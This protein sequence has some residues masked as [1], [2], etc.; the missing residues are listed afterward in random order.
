MTWL[1][2]HFKR[3]CGWCGWGYRHQGH[4]PFNF[5]GFIDPRLFGIKYLGFSVL[6]MA[7]SIFAAVWGVHDTAGRV[8]QWGMFVAS[9]I[10][11]CIWI[12]DQRWIRQRNLGWF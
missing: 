7:G 11:L 8:A 9:V 5:L 12:K 3:T 4:C 6:Y 10:Y 2:N 1:E